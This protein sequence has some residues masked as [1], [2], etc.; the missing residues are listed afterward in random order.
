MEFPAAP[1]LRG[2]GLWP[3]RIPRDPDPAPALPPGSITLAL[4]G[5]VMTGRGIDQILAHPVSPGIPE[6]YVHDAREYVAL[7]ERLHGPV[8]RQAPAAYPWGEAL[9]ALEAAHPDVRILNLE[10]AVTSSGK[11]WAG[12]EVHYRMNP[13]NLDCVAAA[14][15]DVCV[16]SNNHA[17]D[18]GRPALRKTLDALSSAHLRAVGAGADRRE[19]LAPA[20]VPLEGGRSL[21]VFAVGF[22]D[23]GVPGDWAAG[24]GQPGVAYLEEA[25]DLAADE[26]LARI[27]AERGPSDLVLVSIHW[28]SNWGYYVPPRHIRFAHRLVE[29]GVDVVHGHSSHH[30]RPLERYLGKLILYGCGDFIDD[31]EGISGDADFRDDLRILYLPELAATNGTLQRLRMIPF[32]VRRLRLVRASAQDTAWLA[33][34]LTRA[35]APFG[36]KVYATPDQELVLA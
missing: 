36:T 35:G 22:A 18:Y 34:T 6:S 17:M 28:G 4:T 23:S 8:P 15:P 2:I 10:T 30:P 31:Y 12:K 26:L 32:Q 27:A 9:Q 13:A 5:D 33:A 19:A 24:P 16:L 20:R 3:R 7:A 1:I 21:L 14:K 29:G 11:P 25:T